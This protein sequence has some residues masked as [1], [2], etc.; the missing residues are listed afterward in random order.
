MLLK[1]FC[2]Q[3]ELEK[4]SFCFFLLN[5]IVEDWYHFFMKCL[6]GFVSVITWALLVSILEVHEFS[7]P[8]WPEIYRV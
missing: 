5:E 7:I 1:Y 2:S 8:L 4:R 3:D 6:T